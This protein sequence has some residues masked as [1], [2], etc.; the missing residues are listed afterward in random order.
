MLMKRIKDL[1]EGFQGRIGIYIKDLST[2]EEWGIDSDGVYRPA[3]TIKI[4]IL[5]ELF[6][7]ANMNNLSLDEKIIV[8]E[9][10]I[11]KGSGILKELNAGKELTLKELAILMIV[12]S[13]NTATNVLMDRLGTGNINNS[14]KDLGLK[15]TLLGRKM[16]LPNPEKIP[17]PNTTS[18]R[19]MGMVLEAMINTDKISV[20]LKNQMLDILK[21]QQK[22]GNI[23]AMLPRGTVFA[24][25]GGGLP[26]VSH[27]VGILM[28]DD[29]N[30]IIA[31]MN[32][33]FQN[34]YDAQILHNKIGRLIYDYF[35]IQ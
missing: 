26:T 35:I 25:K 22:N 2:G 23:P 20:N 27:D 6:Y 8:K 11:V 17:S 1:I 3:S 33:D 7:Q 9:E 18:P 30:I 24:H 19:D 16:M 28:L 14:M 32:E 31:S 4:C 21:R 5:W 13:D 29:K 15:N 12:I 34:R 10:D